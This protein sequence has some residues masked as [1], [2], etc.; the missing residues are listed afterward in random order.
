M[1]S[2]RRVWQSELS[3]IDTA[4]LL[5]GILTASVYFTDNTQNETEIRQLADALYRRVDWR[6]A[7]NGKATLSQG[8]K[9][10]CGFLH[11]GWEGY[12]EATI[13]YV[14]GL[15]SP[16]FPLPDDS[17]G[18]WTSTY[19]W[20]NLYGYDFLYA[21]PLF[22]H[23]FAH[24]WIDFRGLRDEFMREKGSDYF[25]NSR[26]AT[27]IQREYAIRNPREFKGYGEDY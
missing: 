12:S 23:Q 6:W 21:G 27:Y 19:Q 22:I 10:E 2:G 5:A 13:L 1:Q 17:Y 8:W 25:E 4:L 24:A 9:P 15:A 3:L 26:R 20:E 18:A 16:T 14:L 7:Q 11:Y